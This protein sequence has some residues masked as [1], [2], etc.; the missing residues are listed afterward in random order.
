MILHA[1]AALSVRQRQSSSAIRTATRHARSAFSWE[2]R[3]LDRWRGDPGQQTSQPRFTP[4]R[5]SSL[6]CARRRPDAPGGSPFEPSA[7]AL[8]EQ[9]PSPTGRCA[10]AAS[11]VATVAFLS[12]LRENRGRGCG[13]F[14]GRVLAGLAGRSRP[15]SPRLSA[16]YRPWRSRSWRYAGAGAATNRT[17]LPLAGTRARHRRRYR[18]AQ[19]AARR[20]F[21]RGRESRCL[22]WRFR[23]RHRGRHRVRIHG[24]CGTPDPHNHAGSA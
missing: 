14:R 15:H 22:R 7:Q 4:A 8:S 1:N 23:G 2:G 20:S 11:R 21:G 3:A 10:R 19:A 13:L 16:W 24:T 5:P 6:P 17:S 18:R 9:A 12:V